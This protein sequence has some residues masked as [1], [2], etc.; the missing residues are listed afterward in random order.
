MPI[1]TLFEAMRRSVGAR[2]SLVLQFLDSVAI[3]RRELGELLMAPSARHLARV[4]PDRELAAKL[5]PGLMTQLMVVPLGA[6]EGVALLAMADARDD[7]AA[8]EVVFHLGMPVKRGSAEPDEILR[9]LTELARD[10]ARLQLPERPRFNTPLWGSAS[11][12]EIDGRPARPREDGAQPQPQSLAP[13]TERDLH[14]QAQRPSQQPGGSEIPIPLF[15][16]SPE[17]VAATERTP[18]AGN[19]VAAFGAAHAHNMGAGNT[20]PMSRSSGAPILVTAK[21]PPARVPTERPPPTSTSIDGRPRSSPEELAF[22]LSR[23]PQPQKEERITRSAASALAAF[24]R[25]D[26]NDYV[27]RILDASSRD[28][29]LSLLLQGTERVAGRAA[30]FV[31]RRGEFQGWTCTKS[32][33]PRE[34]LREVRLPVHG[35]NILARASH[36]DGYLGP[37]ADTAEHR[38]LLGITGALSADVAVWPVFVDERVAIVVVADGLVDTMVGTRHLGEL[39]R[40]AGQ[41]LTRLLRPASR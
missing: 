36:R 18:H 39:T 4:D 27:D 6:F 32:F 38:S 28:H 20:V 31:A 5:P 25:A 12:P 2:S 16:R 13:S 41:A 33:A 34:A 8:E 7:H 35:G 15:R 37:I 40:A 29:I 17:D 19:G 3:D 23:P 9:A 24:F 26:E 30:L 1:R 22:V 11:L 21:L 10:T 14:A